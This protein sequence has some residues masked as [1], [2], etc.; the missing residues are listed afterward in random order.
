MKERTKM[1]H[2]VKIQ[3]GTF[4]KLRSE[5]RLNQALI[6]SNDPKVIRKASKIYQNFSRDLKFVHDRCGD[7]DILTT[8]LAK[9][10]RAD[11]EWLALNKDLPDTVV[12]HLLF[13]IGTK[14]RLTRKAYL[15]EKRQNSS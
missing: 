10:M 8:Y 1:K 2:K 4:G 3:P 7:D 12:D 11:T 5:Q 14:Y 9:T 15:D 13:A 6:E